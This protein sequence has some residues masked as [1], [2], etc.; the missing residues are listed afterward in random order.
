MTTGRPVLRNNTTGSRYHNDSALAACRFCTNLRHQ[1]RVMGKKVVEGLVGPP[2]A[3][4]TGGLKA[5]LP[6]PLG[7]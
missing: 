6:Q 2:W 7:A 4:D 5:A 3:N 1:R